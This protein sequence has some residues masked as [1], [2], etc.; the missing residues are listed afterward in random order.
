VAHMVGSTRTALTCASLQFLTWARYPVAVS[1]P[2]DCEPTVTPVTTAPRVHTLRLPPQLQHQVPAPASQTIALDVSDGSL[3]AVAALVAG[4][5][6]I[7][8]LEPRE[9]IHMLVGQTLR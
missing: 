6:A 9:V 4:C 5:G 3:A 7:V 8:S 2:L 1:V